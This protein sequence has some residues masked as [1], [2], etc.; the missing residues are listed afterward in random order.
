VRKHSV[1]R[2]AITFSAGATLLR[3]NTL[4]IA[5]VLEVVETAA[6]GSPFLLAPPRSREDIGFE[7][8]HCD[9]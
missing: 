5:W 1:S 7:W 2:K 8:P 9:F 6:C 3:L 4:T